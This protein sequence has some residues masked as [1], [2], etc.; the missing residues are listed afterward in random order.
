[1]T[2]SR[3][4]PML[5]FL[6]R[7]VSGTGAYAQLLVRLG[8]GVHANGAE[9]GNGFRGG[10][11]E[12]N[13]VL[14]AN[15]VGDGLANVIHLAKGGRKECDSSSAI[16]NQFQRPLRLSRLLVPEQ[17]DGID[18]GAVFLLQDVQRSE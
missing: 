9:S 11:C 12:G 8:M 17:P 5:A 18:D 16:G 2:R 15:V 3:D 7:V 10:G 14:V 4:H 6:S 13:G 1:M